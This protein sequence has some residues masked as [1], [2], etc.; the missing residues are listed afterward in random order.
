MPAVMEPDA[1]H[2]PSTVAEE[3][4]LNIVRKTAWGEG[5]DESLLRLL[6]THAR[7][8]SVPADVLICTEGEH[9]DFMAFIVE[10]RLRVL[11]R[12]YFEMAQ[13]VALLGP[14]DTF[15]EMAL[16]DSEDRSASIQ[17]VEPS[18]LLVLS[19]ATFKRLLAENQE[20]AVALLSQVSRVLSQRIR[21]LNRRVLEKL[22]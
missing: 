16:V 7:L 22:A 9:G 13:L 10:G 5:L 4:L 3:R 2:P 14:G 18:E 17:A 20:A 21:Y 11:K 15:G 6:V 12:D 1:L 8:V 19:Q